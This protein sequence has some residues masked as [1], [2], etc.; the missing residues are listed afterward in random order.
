MKKGRTFKAAFLIIILVLLVLGLS[1]A[2]WKNHYEK[3]LARGH[4]NVI[5]E[6]YRFTESAR[7]LQNPNRGFYYMHG[8]RIND[9]E[10][11]FR[12]NIS[13]RFCKD[14]KTKLTLIQINLQYYRDKPISE[15]GLE[16]IEALFETL[17]KLDKNLIIRFVYDW[18]GENME[19]EPES[20]DI[21][22]E[23][24]RQVGPILRKYKD[25]IFTLQ[26]LFIGNW[27]EMNGTKY[28]NPQDVPKLAMQ[29][30]EVTDDT[31]FLAVRMPMFWRIATQ[32]P[33]VATVERGD[34]SLASRL[35]LYNDGMLGS[36]SDYG[37]YGDH[38]KEEHGYYTYWNREQ[39]LEFQEELCK[40]VPSGGEVIVDNSYNDFENALQDMQRMHV[41]YLNRDYDRNV[42]NKWEKY[43]VTE[44]GCFDGMDGLSYIERHLGYR[45][46]IQD[47]KMDYQY[48]E[49]IL[50]VDIAME[51][52]GF[53][54][55]YRE[56]EVRVVL[57]SEETGELHS[58][59]VTQDIRGLTGGTKSEESLDLQ[60]QIPLAGETA[61]G[62]RMY[63]EI[64]DALSGE[65][66]E[67]ANEQ[68]AMEYGYEIGTINIEPLEGWINNLEVRGRK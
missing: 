18:N 22:L 12:Q 38:T 9:E 19:Y 30:A 49:D 2:I 24:M 42:L 44:E 23:H 52:V 20:V 43:T 4:G 39:E 3:M 11:D 26:G 62:Y 53:A 37:T 60:V 8:F 36:W 5:T 13:N 50:S 14:E 55:M 63:L 34:G 40:L 46:L 59:E 65:P 16:N 32:L 67:L 48:E 66:I 41:T 6:S 61:K 33:D 57:F 28:A 25:C 68:E 10:A 51:N 7:E 54:P 1:G 31:T 58:Y 45:L 35:G 15:Q 64:T 17:E 47:V 56:A 21:I 27:G 29:L